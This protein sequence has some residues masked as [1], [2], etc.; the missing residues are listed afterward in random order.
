MGEI[1][2]MLLLHVIKIRERKN[3]KMV[4]EKN[5]LASFLIRIQISFIRAHTHDLITFQRLHFLYHQIR[6]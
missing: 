4:R 3:R 1:I 2:F 6:A 5:V